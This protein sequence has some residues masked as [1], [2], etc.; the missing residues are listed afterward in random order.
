MNA[1]PFRM[2][3]LLFT[4]FLRTR[5]LGGALLATALL[6]MWCAAAQAQYA[7]PEPLKAEGFEARKVGGGLLTWFGFEIYDASL[8]SSDGNFAGLGPELQQPVAFSLWYHRSFSRER[9]IDIT[10]KG[11]RE[12]NLATEAQQARWQAQLEKI[13]V[14]TSDGSN[15]TALV[16][17]GK[18]TRFYN[19]ERLLGRIPDADFG[20]AFLGIWLDERTRGTRLE[21]LRTALLGS[22]IAACSQ[23]GAAN[24]RKTTHKAGC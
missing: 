4:L 12:F 15:M 5:R 24:S 3:I 16:L 18:E 1:R 19:A 2:K 21:D 22:S 23:R 14:D 10:L 7:L 9:L 11:W 13:W 20:P 6:G 8:W 17:P